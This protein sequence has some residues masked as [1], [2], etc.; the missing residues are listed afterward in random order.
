MSLPPIAYKIDHQNKAFLPPDFGPCSSELCP[1]SMF[2]PRCQPVV[3]SD[4]G[5][6]LSYCFPMTA[7]GSVLQMQIIEV[8]G[9]WTLD[10]NLH[11][12]LYQYVQM[13]SPIPQTNDGQ[14][15]GISFLIID[16]II[17]FVLGDVYLVMRIYSLTRNRCWLVLSQS[18]I[19]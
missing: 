16:S 3:I 19:V 11:D 7:E 2:Q 15:T 12:F 6:K 4:L 9:D 1:P 14:S 17:I 8:S 18:Q 10:Y 5:R 13:V